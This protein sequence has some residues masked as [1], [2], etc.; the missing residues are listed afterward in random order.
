MIKNLSPPNKA[1]SLD[2]V[3]LFRARLRG[4]LPVVTWLLPWILSQPTQ[5]IPTIQDTPKKPKDKGMDVFYCMSDLEA[6]SFKAA[7]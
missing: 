7:F 2:L 3:T 6:A 4:L 5:N 1:L